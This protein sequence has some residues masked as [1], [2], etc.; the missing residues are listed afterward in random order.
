M[1]YLLSLLLYCVGDLISRP[2]CR[3]DLA[4]LYPL[5]NWLMIKSGDLDTDY[6]LWKSL[7][8]SPPGA[9]GP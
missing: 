5:Y 8:R 3:W 9:N 2:M 4:F 6:R 1:K 7:R